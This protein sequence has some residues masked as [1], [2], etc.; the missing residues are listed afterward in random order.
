MKAL[1]SEKVVPVIAS[2]SE[3]ESWSP[4]MEEYR[5]GDIKYE[6]G[7]LTRIANETRRRGR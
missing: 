2:A 3:L 4:L 1:I 7:D 5:R 6:L